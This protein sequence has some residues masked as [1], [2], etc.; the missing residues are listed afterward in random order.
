MTQHKCGAWY[1]CRQKR[2]LYAVGQLWL[3]TMS[4][5]YI[6]AIVIKKN[7]H[8][9]NSNENQQDFKKILLFFLL[10]LNVYLGL[11][12]WL[13]IGENVFWEG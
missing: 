9:W 12:F 6:S 4:C 8:S 5:M 2:D 13:V 1:N 3:L 7:Y 11:F 10:I